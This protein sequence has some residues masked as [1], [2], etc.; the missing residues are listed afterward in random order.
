MLRSLTI[1][2]VF[3]LAGECLSALL[4]WPVPGPVLGMLLL[5]SVLILRGRLSAGL[6]DDAQH[7]LRYL[8]LILIPPSVGIMDH[9]PTLREEGLAVGLTIVLT[10]IFSLLLAAGLMRIML[11]RKA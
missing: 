8:P 5:L 2:L 7:L 10:T 1:L 3:Q 11:G 6:A 9:G 4:N